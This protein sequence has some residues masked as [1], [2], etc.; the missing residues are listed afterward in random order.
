MLSRLEGL[1]RVSPKYLS[2]QE[3]CI[4]LEMGVPPR[5]LS[6]WIPTFFSVHYHWNKTGTYSVKGNSVEQ[7]MPNQV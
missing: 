5:I 7:G 1:D 3:T 4:S 2:P 6:P